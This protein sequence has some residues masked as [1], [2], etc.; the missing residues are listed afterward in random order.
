M[1]IAAPLGGGGCLVLLKCALY[2]HL[3]L[4]LQLP[5]VCNISVPFYY[6]NR[7][8]PSRLTP[9]KEVKNVS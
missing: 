3:L 6:V 9:A 4:L 1:V 8:V 7:I 5:L 2:C